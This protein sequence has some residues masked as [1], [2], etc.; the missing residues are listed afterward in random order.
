MRF[1]LRIHLHACGIRLSRVPSLRITRPQPLSGMKG[2]L[3]QKF[4][5][6]HALIISR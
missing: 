4:G 2:Y 5:T 6:D 3:S 1:T